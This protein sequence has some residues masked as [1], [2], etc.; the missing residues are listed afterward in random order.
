MIMS[1]AMEN[2]DEKNLEELKSKINQYN[3]LGNDFG[4]DVTKYDEALKC[5]GV[6]KS[7]SEK[8]GNKK[9][10]AAALNNMGIIYR[11]KGILDKAIE[12]FKEA[13]KIREDIRDRDA[14]CRSLH[15]LSICSEEN[16][17][18]LVARDYASDIERLRSSK[19]HPN[20][21]AN[22]ADCL[23]SPIQ[24]DIPSYLERMVH[25]GYLKE[26]E[27]Y[28]DLQGI[29]GIKCD[30]GRIS[31][32][33]GNIDDAKA[34]FS[35]A[36]DIDSAPP[37]CEALICNQL[38]EIYLKEKNFVEARSYFRQGYQKSILLEKANPASEED[39][40]QL[41]LTATHCTLVTGIQWGQERGVRA[42]IANSL[43][44]LGEIALMQSDY[45]EAR[46]IFNQNLHRDE[47]SGDAKGIAIAS[48]L[49][50]LTYYK[51]GDLKS[52][53]SLFEKSY[54]NI[55]DKDSLLED[56]VMQKRLEISRMAP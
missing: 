32:Q 5:Y 52:A 16:Q 50:G 29:A 17:D 4:M 27:I 35:E 31:E 2:A 42:W 54:E 47:K 33:M 8:L 56:L 34:Y 26:R 20:C 13:R 43:Q 24:P 22:R 51:Q 44:K 30:L 40:D 15:Y 19:N 23:I 28:N 1:T 38:G 53:R 55:E 18:Y 3:K 48:F 9:C 45:K 21:P 37:A 36:L 7:A 39:L 11:K 6:V 10:T 14:E 41:R 49:I 12:C 25:E 46:D